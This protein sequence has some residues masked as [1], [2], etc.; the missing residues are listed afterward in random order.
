MILLLI[1]KAD[2]LTEPE[3]TEAVPTLH[4][5]LRRIDLDAPGLEA[6]RDRRSDLLDH[7]ARRRL[8]IHEAEVRE[9][10]RLVPASER[11][12]S[13]LMKC[14]QLRA[15]LDAEIE[16]AEVSVAGFRSGEAKGEC[17]R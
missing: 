2:I 11:V 12:A 15:R 3:A 8:A 17:L 13:R 6:L 9:Q 5:A 16:G 1:S 10:R 14:E 4:L 7:G